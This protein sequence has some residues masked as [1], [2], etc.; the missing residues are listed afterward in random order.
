MTCLTTFV[1][2][3]NFFLCSLIYMALI[4]EMPLIVV[5]MNR[6][7]MQFLLNQSNLS[8]ST[9]NSSPLLMTY[10]W[11]WSALIIT[12][13][14]GHQTDWFIGRKWAI[15][16]L[17]KMRGERNQGQVLFIQLASTKVLWDVIILKSLSLLP[18]LSDF[19]SSIKKIRCYFM[20]AASLMD[21][22]IETNEV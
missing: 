9:G 11:T 22:A 12:F 2:A 8:N 3:Y 1:L 7:W 4:W 21:G 6:A 14:T 18:A 15:K 10:W 20:F 5:Y 17:S 19:P 13:K 16:R